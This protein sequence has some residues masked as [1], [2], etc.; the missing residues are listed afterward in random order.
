MELTSLQKEYSRALPGDPVPM[1]KDS[2]VKFECVYHTTLRLPAN[3]P[4]GTVD[5]VIGRV[6]GVHIRDDVLT[7]G[8]LD[9]TKTQ[10]IARCGYF[11]YTVV[12]ETFEMIIP[13]MDEAT[14]AGLEGN[15]A[16]HKKVKMLENGSDKPNGTPVI[17]SV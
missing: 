5:V 7:D 14:H 2:P 12:R 6:I 16:I 1:V 13:G 3:P 15:S 9:V 4:M 17:K 10:P 8:K 11:Q